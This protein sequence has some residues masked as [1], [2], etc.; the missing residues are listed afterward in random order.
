MGKSHALHPRYGGVRI[1]R[2]AVERTGVLGWRSMLVSGCDLGILALRLGRIE[3]GERHRSA[4]RVQW[5]KLQRGGP[6][7]THPR[8]ALHGDSV[9]MGGLPEP[10]HSGAGGGRVVALVGPGW[11]SGG[12]GGGW[13]ARWWRRGGPVVAL[14][15]PVVARGSS[16]VASGGVWWARWWRRCGPGGGEPLLLPQSPCLPGWMVGQSSAVF[17]SRPGHVPQGCVT[18]ITVDGVG[19][20][21]AVGCLDGWR[22]AEIDVCT[23]GNPSHDSACGR[24]PLIAADAPLRC[25]RCSAG[26]DRYRPGLTLVASP[27]FCGPSATSCGAYANPCAR[28]STESATRLPLKRREPSR[29]KP[30]R[31]CSGCGARASSSF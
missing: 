7:A 28:L 9:P 17:C 20:L 2:V 10:H 13:W 24:A 15:G 31:P 5:N 12:P 3:V 4:A 29:L 18:S 27:T 23:E 19:C 14:V 25:A 8:L 11:R 6:T 30:R 22:L 21:V 26:R 16:L 1:V